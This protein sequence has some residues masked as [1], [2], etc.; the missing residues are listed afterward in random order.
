MKR[1]I[2]LV[3]ML[4]LVL[5]VAGCGGGGGNSV[6]YSTLSGT[7][8]DA[9]SRNPISEVEIKVGTVVTATS[10]TSGEFTTP[11]FVSGTYDITF[12]KSGYATKTY[13]SMVIGSG[14]YAFDNPIT[15]QTGAGGESPSIIK[16]VPVAGGSGQ[17]TIAANGNVGTLVAI[18]YNTALTSGN[19]STTVSI[20]ADS[21]NL[22]IIPVNTKVSSSSSKIDP[23]AVIRN[24]EKQLLSSLR[25]KGQLLSSK[26]IISTNP[27]FID[28]IQTTKTFRKYYN[29]SWVT[30]SANKKYGSSTTK[31]QIYLQDGVSQSYLS[32][33]NITN[34]GLAFDS[35]YNRET[36]YFGSPIGT[37]GD[38]DNNE[39][40]YI[41]I[42]ELEHNSNGW[43]AGY[44]HGVHEFPSS[45]YSNSNQKE[46]LFIT[47]YKPTSRSDSEWLS[48][49]QGTMAHEFQHLIFFNNRV[50]KY[51]TDPEYD[52]EVWINEGLS[53]VAED[54]A[55]MGPGNLHNP[56]LDDRVKDYLSNSSGN[57][58][59]TWGDLVADYAPAYMFMR[60][61]VDRYGENNINNLLSSYSIGTNMLTTVATGNTFTQLFRDWLTAVILDRLN[62]NSSDSSFNNNYLYQT[63]NLSTYSTFNPK[64]TGSLVFADSTGGFIVKDGLSGNQQITISIHGNS[65]FGLRLV[66]IPAIGNSFS[67]YGEQPRLIRIK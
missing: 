23:M 36:N 6:Q 17:I 21:T 31:C 7:I 50:L 14:S 40:I 10:N 39:M 55:I 52:S 64:N 46:M 37:L 44:F 57:S 43:V 47:T 51:N 62:Y 15:I 32:D 25:S 60:Y 49:I 1:K 8:I 65:V 66:M 54:L 33:A 24:Q 20:T 48:I 5:I 11:Q 45:E 27:D 30:V 18:P 16:D 19:Y 38:I 58:L 29:N 3:L 35:F 42:T 28:D 61:F 41:L 56:D 4:I 13:Y 9:I 53:M 63:L 12:S 2:M 67:Q 59:C 34:L 26:R 22:S